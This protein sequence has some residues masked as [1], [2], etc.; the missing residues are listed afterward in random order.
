MVQAIKPKRLVPIHTFQPTRFKE[1]FENNDT[2][3]ETHNDD[4]TFEVA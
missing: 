4:E 3:V 1:L 2:I